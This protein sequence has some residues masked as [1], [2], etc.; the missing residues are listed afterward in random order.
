MHNDRSAIQT[1]TSPT[2]GG[3][4]LSVWG[5]PVIGH[6]AATALLCDDGVGLGAGVV[7][8]EAHQM[9]LASCRAA[10][11]TRAVRPEDLMRIR[12]GS[13]VECHGIV[14]VN[15]DARMM[16]RRGLG[17]LLTEVDMT[18]MNHPPR[19]RPEVLA[20]LRALRFGTETHEALERFRA[21]HALPPRLDAAIAGTAS[22]M[23]RYAAHGEVCLRRDGLRRLQD[24]LAAEFPG[25]H[26]MRVQPGDPVFR[27]RGWA[28]KAA[29]A[30]VP[31]SASDHVV[32]M[33]QH[34]GGYI[35]AAV[36]A[37]EV[38][39]SVS[40]LGGFS[41]FAIAVLPRP[42]AVHLHADSA[43]SLATNVQGLAFAAPAV[44][45]ETRLG[46]QCAVAVQLWA[47]G[48]E[49]ARAWHAAIA[50]AY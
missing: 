13:C 17:E 16:D 22:A 42:L 15:M 40:Q 18:L 7:I 4:L 19:T 8:D 30:T 49:P 46:Q 36:A 38:S 5:C 21:A 28:L 25:E 6:R 9:H 32:C 27:P 24:V 43:V 29:E 33:F 2:F 50:A 45:D 10:T 20:E 1:V 35:D 48:A 47:A 37:A 12:S 39:A 26:D 41:E 31:K 23:R 44:G 14:E 3:A 34:T 11:S